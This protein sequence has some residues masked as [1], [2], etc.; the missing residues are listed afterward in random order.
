MPIPT[1]FPSC[2]SKIW[3]GMEC[4]VWRVL[5]SVVMRCGCQHLPWLEKKIKNITSNITWEVVNKTTKHSTRPFPLS[6]SLSFWAYFGVAQ[7]DAWALVCVKARRWFYAVYVWKCVC[8]GMFVCVVASVVGPGAHT[9]TQ[10]EKPERNVIRWHNQIPNGV[11]SKFIWLT[12]LKQN[13]ILTGPV[14]PLCLCLSSRTTRHNNCIIIFH[15]HS[16]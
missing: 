8:V 1:H 11:N 7:L 13:A 16:T 6:L 5:W 14:C 15:M 4:A 3:T 10:R 2:S 12:K 9:H